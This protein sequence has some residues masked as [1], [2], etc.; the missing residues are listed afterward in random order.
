MDYEVKGELIDFQMEDGS[1]CPFLEIQNIA[2]G[3]GG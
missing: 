3:K 2:L 1:K